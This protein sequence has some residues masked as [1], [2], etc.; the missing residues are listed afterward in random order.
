[1]SR[2]YNFPWY[3]ATNLFSN[4]HSG[5]CASLYVNLRLTVLTVNHVSLLCKANQK[6]F[7]V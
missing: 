5:S 1:M 7:F 6:L 3:A 2:K 4:F